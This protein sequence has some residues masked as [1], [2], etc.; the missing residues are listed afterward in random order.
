MRLRALALAIFGAAAALVVA[1]WDTGPANAQ[2]T[3][4]GALGPRPQ[5]P[6]AGPL[7]APSFG[8]G[9]VGGNYGSPSDAIG[10]IEVVGNQRVEPATVRSYMTVAP[11][12]RFEP[13]KIDASLK[14]LFATG[15]FADVTLRREGNVL[16]VSVVEN[17]IINRIAFEGNSH[18]SDTQIEKEV[19][20][21]PRVIYT[22]SKVQSDVQ[23]IIEVYRRAGRFA[24]TVDPKIIQLPQNRVD[25]V[26][27]I[28]EGPTTGIRRI[29]FIGNKHFSDSTLRDAIAT[30]ET[31]W[32]RFLTSSDNYDPDRLTY[33]R[34]LLRR[35]YLT[36]GYA[37]FR[38]VSAVAELTPD[39]E[40]FFI[41]FTV[42]E[43]ELYNVSDSKVESK[44]A[45]LH[46]EALDENLRTKPGDVYN[47]EAI[48]KT[49]D[50]LTFEAGRLGYAFVDIRPRIAHDREK[51]E[52]AITYQ[53]N[54]APRVYV[55]RINITGNVRTLDKVVRREF[56]L[57]EGDA[58]NSAKLSRSKERLK[59]LGFF[60]KVDVQEVPGS[61]PDR[62]NINVEVTEKSTGELQLGAGYSTAE[63][64]VGDVSIRER[65][66]LGRGQDLRLGFSLSSKRTQIDL[67]FTEPYF[68][69]RNLAA[70][71]DLFNINRNYQT[72]SGYTQ[73]V[74]GGALR[75]GFPLNEYTRLVGRY[76]LRL[77]RITDVATDASRAVRESAG[78]EVTSSIGY[79]VTYDTRDDPKLPTKGVELSF[80]QDLAG[81][82]GTVKYIRN[83]A[84]GTY[85]YQVA[86]DWVASAGLSGG[87]IKGLGE[88]VRLND[89]F[90]IGGTDF[91]GFKRGG[92][93]PRDLLA[94]DALGGNLYGVGTLELTFP[95]G[96]P[97]QFGVRTSLFTD[98]G[99]L[100]Q[101]D[102]SDPSIVD[103][104][105]IR[106][107]AGV[108]VSWD[109]PFGPIRVDLAHAYLKETYDKTEI[110]RLNF[111]TRF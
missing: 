44:I 51:R 86:E 78:S 85:Y 70:G 31:R 2:S 7:A 24:A 96:L 111:G 54:E 77:D 75:A 64:I 42:D 20:L 62:T 65:N 28:N 41:T 97:E 29:N 92:L 66:L 57:V 19:Q 34:E 16:V 76:T 52:I 58:Y 43:G 30:R 105:A 79:Q 93:G 110:F 95:N 13:E 4:G 67:S 12:D 40:D 88:G 89:R 84:S 91:R 68:L 101:I 33:D 37:D 3:L 46:P 25:L 99:T 9:A 49:I 83:S 27:E 107:S 48:E 21:K 90:Y 14:A 45:D 103:S 26:F 39:R 98:V 11:G 1:T 60:E 82:G 35:H 61:S 100:T 6:T 18:V 17:P 104:G 108:G 81:L 23:R 56:R 72:E 15:L 109:S 59:A 80:G 71:F 36:R 73:K 10:D 87:Y 47:A 8:T 50:D 53:I 102:K 94:D 74:L 63:S 38:V 55:D 22:R 106:G 69:D 5:A 32:W